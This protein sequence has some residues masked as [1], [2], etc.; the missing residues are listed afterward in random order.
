MV[1]LCIFCGHRVNSDEH[2]WPQWLVR[3]GRTWPSPRRMQATRLN[4]RGHRA[5]WDVNHPTIVTKSVCTGCNS[6]WMSDLETIIEPMLTPLING[7]KGTVSVKQQKAIVVWILKCAM[8]FDSMEGDESFYDKVERFHFRE[9]LDPG[10][11]TQF[12]IGHYAGDFLGFLTRY[13]TKSNPQSL[14]PWK[15]NIFTMAFGHVVFQML[16]VRFAK[17]TH[18]RSF[19]VEAYGQWSKRIVDVLVHPYHP[20]EWPPNLSF[21]DIHHTVDQFADRFGKLL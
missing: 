4:R 7:R 16:D 3:L 15:A 1:H 13:G 9:T 12:W 20:I 21:D 18:K 19:T 6:G 14:P 5:T 11:Y 10:S 17:D 8:I 2:V